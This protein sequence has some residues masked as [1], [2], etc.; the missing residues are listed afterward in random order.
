MIAKKRL[1]AIKNALIHDLLTRKDTAL[2]EEGRNQ[3]FVTVT[4]MEL[5]D[6]LEKL[7]E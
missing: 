1:K 5:V 2:L 6:I 3:L 7:T 4:V